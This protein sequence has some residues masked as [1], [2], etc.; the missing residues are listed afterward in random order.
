MKCTFSSP[1]QLW[2]H[3]NPWWN[4]WENRVGRQTNQIAGS[5]YLVFW[6]W[7]P[8]LWSQIKMEQ[9]WN[10]VHVVSSVSALKSCKSIVKWLRKWSRKAK[11]Q[12]KSSVFA[13]IL[14]LAPLFMVPDQNWCWQGMSVAVV[15]V[16]V[17][18]WKPVVEQIGCFLCRVQ[19]RNRVP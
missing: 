18:G 9:I 19:F 13:S 7:C 17:S 11:N 2:N 3:A 4:G 8:C 5:V 6:I 1:S 15:I 16:N 14:A 10:E 12:I